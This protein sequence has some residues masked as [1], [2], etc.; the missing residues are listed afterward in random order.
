M[1]LYISHSYPGK[2]ARLTA[3][4]EARRLAA[5][6]DIW[7][8]WEAWKAI[9]DRKGR[10]WATIRK[11]AVFTWTAVEEVFLAAEQ[12]G[13][14]LTAEILAAVSRIFDFQG[15]S[16]PT[17]ISFQK[18]AKATKETEN[19][20]LS[21]CSIWRAPTDGRVLD[22]VYNF[23]EVDVKDVPDDGHAKAALPTGLY[24]PSLKK[25]SA[26]FL[27]ITG[28]GSPKWDT[29]SAQ[30]FCNLTG[31]VQA[32][33]ILHELGRLDQGPALWKMDF[34]P[35][36][37]VLVDASGTFLL[38]LCALIPCLVT[39]PLEAVSRGALTFLQ[40]K[41]PDENK[42]HRV[43]PEC[44]VI[45]DFSEWQAVPYDFASPA[46]QIAANGGKNVEAFTPD[47]AVQTGEP[48]PLLE[49][50]AMRGFWDR[51]PA[52]IRR[53][54]KQELGIE[55]GGEDNVEEIVAAIKAVLMCDDASAVPCLERREARLSAEHLNEVDTILITEEAEDAVDESDRKE[56]QQHAVGIGQAT[57]EAA[58]LRQAI[59]KYCAN[60]KRTAAASQK[61]R[62]GP[63]KLSP[64]TTR[65][66]RRRSSRPWL[67]K[68]PAC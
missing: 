56:A 50:A 61:K 64:R 22:E 65:A 25:S 33:R 12:N 30:T 43:T 49:Y 41:E 21:P 51:T 24:T 57:E 66:G 18:I 62:E 40:L 4:D 11:G 39:W 45:T 47:F 60:A 54:L 52:S 44:I 28:F 53:L 16:S 58:E 10:P 36:G 68:T 42:T 67:P 7:Q 3:E 8:D 14:R 19:L 31:Q 9:K 55:T 1:F 63:R 48:M 17:E 15:T 34:A 38:V 5:W 13:G 23:P 20:R 6:D 37:T 32:M 59:R 46:D 29:W 35:E 2:F 27:D 26:K